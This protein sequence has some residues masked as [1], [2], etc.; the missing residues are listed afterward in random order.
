MHWFCLLLFIVSTASAD[1]ISLLSNKPIA[2]WNNHVVTA[3][4][5]WYIS[6]DATILRIQ[7]GK[8]S[9]MQVPSPLKEHTN[10]I[11]ITLLSDNLVCLHTR[12]ERTLFITD[13]VNIMEQISVL[14]DIPEQQ[15]NIATLA[16][17]NTNGTDFILI[18]LTN[19]KNNVSY[20]I[21]LKD[22][23]A[24]RLNIT[25]LNTP[26]MV[27]DSKRGH[28]YLSHGRTDLTLYSIDPLNTNVTLLAQNNN[29]ITTHARALMIADSLYIVDERFVIH[30]DPSTTKFVSYVTDDIILD[31]IAA[32]I[33]TKNDRVIIF[34]STRTIFSQFSED[35]FEVNLFSVLQSQNFI[36]HEKL[37]YYIKDN[38][39]MSTRGE[40]DTEILYRNIKVPKVNDRDVIAYTNMAILPHRGLL[41]FGTV[42]LSPDRTAAYKTD[43][44]ALNLKTEL[45]SPLL[46]TCLDKDGNCA[47]FSGSFTPI[48]PES[49]I[50][51]KHVNGSAYLFNYLLEAT[52]APSRMPELKPEYTAVIVLCSL[53]GTIALTFVGFMTANAI[54]RY[55]NNLAMVRKKSY[56]TL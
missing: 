37:L 10:D 50:F 16:H 53:L 34:T 8:L 47:P 1:Q 11:I 26:T 30:Y 28:F 45:L 5:V 23:V 14:Q 42:E 3:E 18:A 25:L 52:P 46:T 48:S 17:L 35:I 2:N 4:S 44:I 39:I 51:T 22:N 49:F 40:N 20:V 9:S 29:T 38:R 13:A 27:S 41:A 6:T 15:T 31:V 21:N 7:S 43:I 33:A 55:R 54:I 12:T 24:T 36:Y 56:E 32:P 19:G